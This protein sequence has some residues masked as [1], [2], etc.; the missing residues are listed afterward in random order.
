[1]SMF[2]RGDKPAERAGARQVDD[3]Q[4]ADPAPA[5]QPAQAPTSQA[6]TARRNA[7]P[8]VISVGLKVTGNLDSED[9][10]QI[11]GT[12]EGDVRAKTVTVGKGATVKGSVYGESVQLAGTIDG[13][14]EARSVTV[15]STGHM[16][17]DIIHQ[18]LEIEANAYVD[19][20]CR[21]HFGKSEQKGAASR[22]STPSSDA[23][24]SSRSAATE[25]AKSDAAAQKS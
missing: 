8:S 10:I 4:P 17:G 19:G 2:T 18:T 6:P 15:K 11:D 23:S 9:E 14:I 7:T 24:P 21:P 12:V 1:M 25:T 5:Q 22:Q 16:E 3:V 13:K 20:H